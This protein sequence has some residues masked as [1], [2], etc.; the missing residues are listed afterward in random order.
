MVPRKRSN[1]HKV[2]CYS[3]PVLRSAK[4]APANIRR[5]NNISDVIFYCSVGER[6]R[7]LALLNAALLINTIK[8]PSLLIALSIQHRPKFS[9][10]SP[11]IWKRTSPHEWN[12]FEWDVKT[13]FNQSNQW[14]KPSKPDSTATVITRRP[15]HKQDE[16]V[17]LISK[18]FVNNAISLGVFPH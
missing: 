8:I 6:S 16:S 11:A 17:E 10:P 1:K 9:R 18:W 4:R 2:T 5:L 13:A 15:Q 7:A 14:N 3:W 12:M